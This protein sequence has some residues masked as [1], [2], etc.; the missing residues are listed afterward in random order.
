MTQVIEVGADVCI[1][2]GGVLTDRPTVVDDE[3]MGFVR[4]GGAR[5]MDDARGHDEECVRCYRQRQRYLQH[6]ER[7]GHLV[8]TQR[9]HD[10][11][12]LHACL[13]E[14]HGGNLSC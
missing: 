3:E 12:Q 5:Q 10:G 9:S 14:C 4:A 1:D 8:S 6:D 13:D 2:L 11:A 7:S